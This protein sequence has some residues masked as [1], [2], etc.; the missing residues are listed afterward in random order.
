[1]ADRRR[2]FTAVRAQRSAADKFGLL[3][4][5]ETIFPEIPLDTSNALPRGDDTEG[6]PTGKLM[7]VLLG[8]AVAQAI[9]AAVDLGLPDA[10]SHG[11]V[12]LD[13]LVRATGCHGPSLERL[14]G[15][16]VEAE[17]LRREA[18]GALGLTSMGE[19]LRSDAAPS[20]ATAAQLVGQEGYLRAWSGL[21][22]AVRTGGV[23]GE[24]NGAGGIPAAYDGPGGVAALFRS[25]ALGCVAPRL[26]QVADGY[27]F[28][29]ARTLVDL[30][31]GDGALLRVLLERLPNARAILFERPAVIQEL[32]R[33]WSDGPLSDHSGGKGP[34]AVDGAPDWRARC[35]L[36]EGDFFEH[37]PQGGDVYLLVDVLRQWD[38]PRTL[39]LL[40]TVRRAMGSR[41]RILVVEESAPPTAASP[42]QALYELVVDSAGLC[43]SEEAYRELLRRSGFRWVQTSRTPGAL[44]LIEAAPA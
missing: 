4:T 42:L 15:V 21:T 9:S 1:V 36:L 31:G 10:L 23:S 41:S 24:G 6:T 33:R 17:I 30:G 2:A 14:V 18:D 34:A 39:R 40:A 37:A 35:E 12:A 19:L 44:H 20:L 32:R 11:A 29:A 7:G 38:E 5:V 13:A 27:D 25:T 16:L 26:Q 8:G 43:R 28:S 22:Q 3:S